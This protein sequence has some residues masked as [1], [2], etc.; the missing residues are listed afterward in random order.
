MRSSTDKK[1]CPLFSGGPRPSPTG[2]CVDFELYLFPNSPPN[3][4]LK[5]IK[6]Q[7]S[8]A[9]QRKNCGGG[10]DDKKTPAD[11]RGCRNQFI[12]LTN[13][14]ATVSPLTTKLSYMQGPTVP[15]VNLKQNASAALVAL[16][17]VCCHTE[18]FLALTKLS[19]MK[20]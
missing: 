3:P 18:F 9:T 12:K 5:V 13:Y 4:N 11:V 15:S 6:N 10:G 19:L 17:S 20:T 8:S 16:A 1:S 2:L 14:S 7:S